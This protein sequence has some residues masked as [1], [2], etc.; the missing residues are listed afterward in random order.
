MQNQHQWPA[1]EFHLAISCVINAE[2]SLM[3]EDLRTDELF[4]MLYEKLLN[5]TLEFADPA[6]AC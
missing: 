2:M 3:P 1:K 6:G 5:S 4:K